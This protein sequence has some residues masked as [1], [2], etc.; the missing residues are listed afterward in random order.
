MT[1][2]VTHFEDLLIRIAEV[3]ELRIAELDTFWLPLSGELTG[4]NLLQ[5]QDPLRFW[6]C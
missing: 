4:G 1:L 3:E 5:L 2:T 6:S